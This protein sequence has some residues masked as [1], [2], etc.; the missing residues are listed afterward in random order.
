M[1]FFEQLHVESESSHT[2]HYYCYYFK[3][4]MEIYYRQIFNTLIESL[5]SLRIF[6]PY[7]NQR[8]SISNKKEISHSLSV[9]IIRTNGHALKLWISST[10]NS[11]LIS[12]VHFK[13]TL[14]IVNYLFY[15]LSSLSTFIFSVCSSVIVFSILSCLKIIL[16]TYLFRFLS[17]SVLTYRFQTLI[18]WVIR[19]LSYFQW[20]SK[21]Q[22]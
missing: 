15:I 17:G 2:S 11:W 3:L 10:L 20:Y 19:S 9:L 1:I 5:Y 21:C 14:Y 8:S 6:L 12:S 7:I 18:L 22:Y 13:F 16:T 4:K